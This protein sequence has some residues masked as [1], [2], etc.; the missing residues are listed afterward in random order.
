MDIMLSNWITANK[1]KL[2]SLGVCIDN[3]TNENIGYDNNS[4]SFD[5]QYN[6][7]LARITL[8]HRGRLYAH[9][10]SVESN[11]TIFLFDDVITFNESELNGFLF[12]FI[13]ILIS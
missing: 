11:E 1:P 12:C 5:L 8:N 2:E 13:Q 6:S 9:I 10:I 4:V 7:K 3:I